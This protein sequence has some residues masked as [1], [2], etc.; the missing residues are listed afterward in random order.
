MSW[1]LMDED[2]LRREYPVRLL[3]EWRVEAQGGLLIFAKRYDGYDGVHAD[4]IEKALEV[5]R[6]PSGGFYSCDLRAMTTQALI[7]WVHQ[8]RQ[9]YG[10]VHPSIR[11]ADYG[12]CWVTYED[13]KEVLATRPHIPNKAEGRRRRQENASR[14]KKAKPRRRPNHKR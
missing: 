5:Y 13:I 2:F 3:L 7:Q 1:N 11:A 8:A 12:T 14:G 10:D 6:R 9:R 4:T